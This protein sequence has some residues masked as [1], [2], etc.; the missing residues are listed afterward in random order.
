MKSREQFESI[1]L[2][3]RPDDKQ[4]IEMHNHG[5]AENPEINYFSLAIQDACGWFELGRKHAIEQ[6]NQQQNIPEIITQGWIQCSERMPEDDQMVVIINSDHGCI[7]EAAVVTRRGDH[8]YLMD[9]GLEASNYDGGAVISL[10]IEPT[11]WMPLLAVPE[12]SC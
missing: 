1:F 7:Y 6:Q 3:L 8:F 9:D 11:H 4:L 2:K 10:D 5:T 12:E